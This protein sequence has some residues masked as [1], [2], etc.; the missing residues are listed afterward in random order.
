MRKG[1]DKDNALCLVVSIKK[2]MNPEKVFQGQKRLRKRGWEEHDRVRGFKARNRRAGRL[3]KSFL[4][5]KEERIK[6]SGR[7]KK[8]GEG[9]AY[10]GYA[11]KDEQGEGSRPSPCRGHRQTLALWRSLRKVNRKLCETAAVGARTSRREWASA[12]KDQIG[13]S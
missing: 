8:G 12:K 2:Q 7:K 11:R 9:P 1:E 6:T 5:K 13:L 4:L 10:D 3:T